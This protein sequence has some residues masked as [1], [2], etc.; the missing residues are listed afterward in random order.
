M[1]HFINEMHRIHDFHY[2]ELVASVR[3]GDRET[4]RQSESDWEREIEKET[5]RDIFQH[6]SH[7]Q[8][9]DQSGVCILWRNLW[10]TEI[11]RRYFAKK[12]YEIS[13]RH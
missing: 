11:K 10:A 9:Q 3:E 8:S 13:L 5:E 1:R 2:G 12:I 7:I 6:M 4:E